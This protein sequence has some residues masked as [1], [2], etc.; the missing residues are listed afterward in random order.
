M[1]K[2]KHLIVFTLIIAFAS[3]ASHAQDKIIDESI[4]PLSY[5][6]KLTKEEFYSKTREVKQTPSGDE[7]LAY[8]VRLPQDWTEVSG[9]SPQSEDLSSKL[10]GEVVR[11]VSP[12]E[13][14]KRAL[15]TI[16]AMKMEYLISTKNW[17]LNFIKTN[18]YSIEGMDAS[19]ENKVLAE[20]VV[21]RENVSYLVRAVAQRNGNRMVLAEYMIPPGMPGD[22]MGMQKW[23][24]LTFGLENRDP[25]PPIELQ[26]LPLLD[27]AAFYY[28]SDWMAMPSGDRSLEEMSIA[29]LKVSD[30]PVKEKR[31]KEAKLQDGAISAYY[32]SKKAHPDISNEL[33]SIKDSLSDKNMVLGEII[34]EL[35]RKE[36]SPSYDYSPMTAYAVDI[37]EGRYIDYEYWVTYTESPNSYLIVTL[38]TPARDTDFLEWSKNIS[39]FSLV[40]DS[41]TVM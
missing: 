2:I 26:K 1:N 10:L 3:N 27:V 33:D 19:N 37:V 6:T 31:D 20:Y 11:F 24:I 29:L 9:R 34:L 7:Y 39:A 18:G 25:A 15:F 38:L 17:F 41:F 22:A 23:S 12:P 4:P 8:H 36:R 35:D 32:Y 30:N 28:P 13:I 16:R 21:F 40:A 5:D 14:D